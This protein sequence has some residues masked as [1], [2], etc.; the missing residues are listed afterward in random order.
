MAR[1]H[2]INGESVQFTAEEEIARDAEEKAYAD[3]SAERKLN[4]IKMIRLTKLQET[5]FYALKDV[6]MTD[7]MKTWRQ[8]LRDIPANHTDEAAY[9]L[10]LARDASG[11]LTHSVWSKP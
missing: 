10:L 9:D 6:T 11:N 8:S 5:D 4:T 7:E 3:K 2:L 1:Y